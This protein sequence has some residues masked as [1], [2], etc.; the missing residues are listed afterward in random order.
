MG[1]NINWDGETQHILCCGKNWGGA[2]HNNGSK[3][4]P[5]WVGVLVKSDLLTHFGYHQ[6][7]DWIQKPRFSRVW[8]NCERL[9]KRKFNWSQIFQT[10]QFYTKNYFL[11]QLL[12]NLYKFLD[13][14]N[15]FIPTFYFRAKRLLERKPLNFCQAQPKLNF[16]SGWG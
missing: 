15:C 8:Q 16:N 9:Y 7:T 4:N 6:R 1:E 14:Y 2:P 5:G 12:F 13:S 11:T 10:Q 3:S